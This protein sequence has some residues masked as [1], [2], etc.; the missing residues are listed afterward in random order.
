M[1]GNLHIRLDKADLDLIRRTAKSHNMTLS[2]YVRRASLA[3]ALVKNPEKANVVLLDAL[4]WHQIKWEM[5]RHGVNLNQ[6]TRALNRIALR[7]ANDPLLSNDP[8]IIEECREAAEEIRLRANEMLA[9]YD[10]IESK[11]ERIKEKACILRER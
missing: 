6:A 3:L 2:Q 8:D 1:E 11:V 9:G 10:E 4:T 7:L 5:H